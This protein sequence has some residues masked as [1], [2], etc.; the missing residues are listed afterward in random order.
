MDSNEVKQHVPKLRCLLMTQEDC[1]RINNGG[2]TQIVLN[3]RV[4]SSRG[5]KSNPTSSEG[6]EDD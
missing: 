1:N 4:K 2:A 6:N 3:R 5:N